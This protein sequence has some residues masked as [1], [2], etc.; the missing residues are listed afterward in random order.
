VQLALGALASL[1]VGMLHDGT[2]KG[3]GIV[4]AVTG[5]LTFAG[6]TLVLRWHGTPVRTRRAG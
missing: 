2:P 6:R 5:L 4:I 3:M 1:A